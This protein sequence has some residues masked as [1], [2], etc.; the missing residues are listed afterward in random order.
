MVNVKKYKGRNPNYKAL[1]PNAN[2]EIVILIKMQIRKEY[3]TKEE[4]IWKVKLL[5]LR[6]VIG[7]DPAG[8]PRVCECDVGKADRFSR[9]LGL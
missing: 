3:Q 5:D 4:K 2:L 9:S 1:K 6:D 7:D 8:N